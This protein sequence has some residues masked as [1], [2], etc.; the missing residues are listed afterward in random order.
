MLSM[1]PTRAGLKVKGPGAI[2]T[3]GLLWRNSW[4]H[5]L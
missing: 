2:F 1:L 4:R 5:R 3:G